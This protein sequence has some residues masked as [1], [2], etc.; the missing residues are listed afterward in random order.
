MEGIK[1]GDVV[2]LKSGG[3]DMTVTK[4]IGDEAICDWFANDKRQRGTFKIETLKKDNS[5]SGWE[6]S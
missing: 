1:V 4:I 2:K 3:P 6:A 5:D